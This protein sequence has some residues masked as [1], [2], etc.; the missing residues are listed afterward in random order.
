MLTS[1]A[2]MWKTPST[3]ET[4]SWKS[5][6][7]PFTTFLWMRCLLLCLYLPDFLGENKKSITLTWTHRYVSRST[8]SSKRRAACCSSPSNTTHTLGRA[9][10]APRRLKISWTAPCSPQ[11]QRVPAPPCQSPSPLTLTSATWNPASSRKKQHAHF[12]R[13]CCF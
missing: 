2:Q 10:V 7:R 9:E 1:W 6:G 11:S 12:S 8:C 5:T 3:S 4:R 13:L